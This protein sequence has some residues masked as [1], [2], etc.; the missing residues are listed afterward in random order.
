MGKPC[1][2]ASIVWRGS[3]ISVWKNAKEQHEHHK[4]L[5]GNSSKFLDELAG[6]ESIIVQTTSTLGRPLKRTQPFEPNS[7]PHA[8][9]ANSTKD[10]TSQ[11]IPAA[12]GIDQQVKAF[13]HALKAF[14][15]AL[16][17]LSQL[18]TEPQNQPSIT[19]VTQTMKPS[20][21]KTIDCYCRLCNQHKRC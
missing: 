1:K 6:D 8:T 18:E 19:E 21:L 17:S 20:G 5:K 15:H 10:T 4:Q 3:S 7:L 11:T 13:L 12:E 14:L 9:R 2:T 16:E